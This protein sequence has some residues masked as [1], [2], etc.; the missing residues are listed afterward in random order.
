MH[1]AYYT[2]YGV[3][4]IETSN[5]SQSGEEVKVINIIHWYRER[6]YL[7]QHGPSLANGTVMKIQT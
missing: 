4:N 7:F 5:A 3:Q 2:S 6:C 1:S